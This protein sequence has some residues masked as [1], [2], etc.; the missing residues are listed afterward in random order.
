LARPPFGGGHEDHE[1]NEAHEEEKKR[2]NKRGRSPRLGAEAGATD[3]FGRKALDYAVGNDNLRGTE[4]YREL[5]DA[6]R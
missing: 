5:Y 4:Q 1:E 3:V 6:S 2:G